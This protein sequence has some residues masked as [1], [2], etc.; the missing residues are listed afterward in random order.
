MEYLWWAGRRQTPHICK[1]RKD[2]RKLLYQER[3]A[4]WV[5]LWLPCP[6]KHQAV[7][8]AEPYLPPSQAESTRGPKAACD[9]PTAAEPLQE[10]GWSMDSRPEGM[11]SVSCSQ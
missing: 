7:A 4:G 1:G 6:V 10:L 5:A 8:R 2:C 11:V 9:P 3:R